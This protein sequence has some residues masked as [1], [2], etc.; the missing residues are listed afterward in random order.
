MNRQ[1]RVIDRVVRMTAA[2]LCLVIVWIHIDDQGGIPGDET[3]HY[4]AVAYYLL[5]TVGVLCAA[6]LLAGIGTG[7]HQDTWLLASTVATVPLLGTLLT[8][9]PA[10]P[11]HGR[12]ED[13]GYW[14][15]PPGPEGTVAEVLLLTLALTVTLLSPPPSP[16]RCQGTSGQGPKRVVVPRG[17][18]GATWHRPAFRPGRLRDGPGTGRETGYVPG[19]ERTDRPRGTRDRP[20]RQVS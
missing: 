19:P 20:W 13:G 16:L 18:G 9:L 17:R 8:Q 3:P 15:D 4:V 11:Q 10:P 14:T 5:E 12:G 2:T 1:G 7:R 6:L